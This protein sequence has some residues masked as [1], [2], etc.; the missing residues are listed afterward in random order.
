MVINKFRNIFKFT[1]ASLL[2]AHTALKMIISSIL[3]ALLAPIF[4]L[5]SQAARI[6]TV[7]P[8]SSYSHQIAFWPIWKELSLRGHQVTL[9]TTDP[10]KDPTLTNLTQISISFI[11][12]SLEEINYS[13][14]LIEYQS[15]PIRLMKLFM[16][17]SESTT[18]GILTH[19]GVSKL[20]QNPEVT[21]D[22]VMT[23]YL[24]PVFFALPKKFNSPFI[25]MLSLDGSWIAHDCVGNPTHPVLYP[26]T[27]TPYT[28]NLTFLQRVSSTVISVIMR[29]MAE[30]SIREMDCL[31]EDLF[32]RGYPSVKELACN[33]DMIFV[34]ANPVL[35]F[36]RPTVPA[37]VQI[38]GGTHLGKAKP[39][40][41]EL[42]KFI[43]GG[44]EVV[45]FSLGTNVKCNLIGE[46]LINTILEGFR[47]LP[48]RVIW[49]F[50]DDEL[51]GRPENVKIVKWLPQQ[52]L[53]SELM[54]W[55]PRQL[56]LNGDFLQNTR[57][58]KSS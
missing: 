30:I 44:E 39:L 22:L 6:L 19:E 31:V 18:R 27:M 36:V 56:F 50:E 21:F 2:P 7:V 48:F 5:P 45:Y 28:T 14:R 23:E 4:L 9:I 33:V 43:E 10:I 29:L 24:N 35:N 46:T 25:G 38:G 12:K 42:K 52:D 17:V 3:L 49:K 11:Y 40:P 13:K 57:K 20:M 34:N 16:E 47:E 51:S 26:E 53:L 37:M 58:S 15:D 55:N 32:G 41:E 1:L 8:F 54:R